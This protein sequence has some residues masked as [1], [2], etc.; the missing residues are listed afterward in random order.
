MF[1]KRIIFLAFSTLLLVSAMAQEKK[2]AY[3]KYWKRIDSLIQVKGQPATALTETNKVY[4]L[5]KKEKNEAQQVKALIYRTQLATMKEEDA[6]VKNI[7]MLEAEVSGSSIP[8]QAILQSLIAEKYWQ[9]YQMLRWKLYDRTTTINFVQTDMATWSAD[10]LHKKIGELYLAS[11][12]NEK[13]LQAI[14]LESFEAVII[15][16]NMRYL[17]PTL[18]DLLAHRALDYFKTDDRNVNKPADAFEVDD[19]I[20]FADAFTFVRHPFKTT[21]S[22][23]LHYKAIQLYQRL[24]QYHLPDANPDALI[25]VDI[26]RLQFLYN[27][28]VMEDKTALYRAALSKIISQYGQRAATAQASYLLASTWNTE[29]NQYDPLKDTT[30]R[31]DKL[32]AKEICEAVIQQKDSSEGKANC[33]NLLAEITRKFINLETEKINV[34][35]QP[36]RVLV[37]Y[38]NV[39]QLYL[40]VVKMSRATR[41]QLGTNTWD[42]KYWQQLANLPVIKTFTQTLPD[43]KDY[44]QHRT[45]I[46]A[47]ALPLGEYAFIISSKEDFGLTQNALA[48]QQ[49]Y[50]SKIAYI[51]KGQEYFVLNRES[52]AP[53]VRAAVQVWYKTYDN[54]LGKELENKGENIMTDK[55]GQFTLY[56]SKTNTT[57]NF[58]FEITTPDDRLSLFDYTYNYIRP[59]TGS[60]PK[61][62]N[63]SFLFTDRSIYR[64]GQT[65][66]FKGIVLNSRESSNENAILANF[67]TTLIL[68][69]GNGQKVDSIVMTTNDYGSYNGKFTLPVN[70]LN[71][72]FTILD[73][74]TNSHVNFSV[75]EYKRPKFY[76]EITKPSGTY[77]L[78]D[79]IRVTGTAK[80]YA[81]NNINDAEVKYRVVRK[82]IIPMWYYGYGRMIWPPYGREEVEIA[83]GSM[84]TKADGSFTI[85]FKAL[86]DLH[87]DKKSQPTFQYMVTADI[88][89]INGE[90]RSASNYVSVGYQSLQLT[91]DGPEKLHTDSLKTIR[92]SSTNFN[93]LFEKATVTLTI[94][95]LKTPERIFRNRYWQQPDQFVMTQQQYYAAFPYDIYKDENEVSRWEKGEKIAEVTDTTA[96]NGRFTINKQK[97][98]VGW[99]VAEAITKDKNGETV[100]AVQYIQLFNESGSVNPMA[101]G[102]A[103]ADQLTYEPGSTANYRLVTNLD[104]VFMIHTLGRKNAKDEKYFSLLHKNS[105]PLSIPVSENDRGGMGVQTVFVK[106]N[107]VYSGSESFNVPY[108]NKDLT[109]SYTTYRDK[110]LPGSAEKWKVKIS[111]YKGDKVAAEMLTAMYDESL[112]Q[113]EPHS[114]SQPYLWQEF[115]FTD[116]WDGNTNFAAVQSQE[117]YDND[118]TTVSFPKIYDRLMTGTFDMVYGGGGIRIRGMGTLRNDGA[119]DRNLESQGEMMVQLS[120][121]PKARINE[122]SFSVGYMAEEAVVLESGKNIKLDASGASNA[123][124]AVQTRKNFNETAFFFPDLKTDAEGNIEFSFTMPEALTK[125]KWMT[126]AHTK[127]LAFGYNATSIVTQ[128]ELMVQ[129]N[130]PRFLREGDR[131]DF[132]GKIVN[133]GSKEITG[134]VALQLIDP[135]TNQSVDGWF[136]NVF[137]NQ[138]FTVAA[139]QSSPVSFSLQI[140][141]QYNKPL[142]YRM[143]ASTKASGNDAALSDGEENM[144]AVV[145]NRMLVTESLPLPVRGTGS[146]QF[147]FTKLLQSGNSETLSQHALTIEFTSNPAWYA[148]QT[149]PYLMEYPYECAEQVF[150]RY[151][152]NTLASSIANAAPGVKAIFERWKTKDTAALMS[153]LQKNEELKSVLLQ[154]TP[155]VL[156]A[157]NEAQQKKNIALL[158]DMVRMSSEQ[159]SALTKLKDMQTGTG[160]F[161]WF[162]GGRDDRYITQYIVTS[163]GHLKKLNALPNDKAIQGIVKAAIP[164]LDKALKKDY[165]EL[166]RLKVDLNTQQLSAIQIQ[167]LYMRSFFPEY[168]VPGDVFK[169][170]NYYRKQSQQYWLKQSKYMQGMIA[171][172][173]NRTGD[174]K[175]AT[176]IVKSLKQ[177]ALVNEEM[178]M[179]WK[180]LTAGYY[181]YQNPIESQ[182]LLIET[183]TE[184]TK[185]S[186]AVA[187]MKTWLLKQK[188]TQNWRTTKA[189]ADACYA[190]LLQG[191]DWLTNTPEVQISLGN[192]T[193]N[194]SEQPQEAGTGYFKKVIDGKNVKPEMGN[195]KVNVSSTAAAA[196]ES[197]AWGAVYWQYFENLDKITHAATPLQLNKKLFVEKNTDRGPVLEPLNEGA[198]L[199]VGDKVKVRIELKADRNMEYV[200]MKDMRASCMEPVNVLSSYKWQGGLGYYETT[201]DASTNFFFGYLPKGIFV[202][203]YPLFVTHTGT[204]SNGVTT[205]QCM[206]APEFTSHSEGVKVTVEAK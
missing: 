106:H 181:W 178:G 2:D 103:E 12:K 137:P 153:N 40:R 43:T 97:L 113:F 200:H 184:V 194:S 161:V 5:A 131:I 189:T 38:R 99:Y 28:A 69:D 60:E 16:G 152:A 56:P 195:I 187:D 119:I 138:F 123:A 198:L 148:V 151:Y 203:E 172:S 202:F 104:S 19:A 116:S 179:Y 201:K 206:Y 85:S 10:D 30:H 100:K 11:I 185:D 141:Y 87:V 34:P 4:E 102:G 88:T 64:P 21:D 155:W 98:P 130:A 9:Y 126:L 73:N 81:G 36:F 46:K 31:Y 180:D 50:V 22:T 132:S 27:Y 154:E 74:K 67:T 139:G 120:M 8:A 205:I 190:L 134:Q 196:G 17:R 79:S 112:D 26:A 128:K 78:N 108:T 57:R 66:Y 140:P 168:G 143:V 183:F 93:N 20:A 133:M 95:K 117:K 177:F 59:Q 13:A 33:I 91:F 182:A 197:V 53:I 62:Q 186:K 24:L 171:L 121:A 80:A 118:Q 90:T 47:D 122:V 3:D 176:D 175:T 156:Q 44:Q 52:G 136:Q 109:I 105:L 48:V 160:G 107:R 110:T 41:E 83:H 61:S 125:W 164:Y 42:D 145:S 193:I 65:I 68:Q 39:P 166:V 70:L 94:H 167:Y 1:V 6:I 96:A 188:Q 101:Y 129:P 63:K 114:W 204:F 165:D 144:L 92:I 23:S 158:F 86:P 77:R 18:F 15:K 191:K 157:N 147:T 163:I 199:H 82:T 71:G 58:R 25:D 7:R 173:L 142:T 72:Q 51:D 135:T 35:G 89:D 127:E 37:T 32:K 149:L 146:K 45:E 115:R 169:A 29:S 170:Y 150:N 159:Q 54:K 84:I 111:G 14:K 174:I 162:K 76:A 49:F 75:E 124:P 192:Y 55:N